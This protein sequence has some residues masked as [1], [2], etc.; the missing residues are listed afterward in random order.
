M[1]CPGTDL[2]SRPLGMPPCTL[3]SSICPGTAVTLAL[4]VLALLQYT[5]WL[6]SVPLLPELNC[7]PVTLRFSGCKFV[8]W[9]R[10]VWE[11]CQL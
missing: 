6:A 8:S 9:V 4:L 2:C 10:G 1:E 5:A 7:V 11:G 3:L